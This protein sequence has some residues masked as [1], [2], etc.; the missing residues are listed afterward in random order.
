MASHVID[1]ISRCLNCAKPA[2]REGCPINTPI[3]EMIEL[4]KEHRLNEAGELLFNNNPLSV[5]CSVVCNHECQCEGHCVLGRKGNSVQISTIENY[6]SETCLDKMQ[7]SRRPDNGIA[8]AVI[9]SGPAGLTVAIQLARKGYRVTIFDSKDKL[10]G[11][12]QYGI[13]DF[14]LPKTLL[15]RLKNKIEELGVRI[16][17]NTTIGNA[18]RIDDMF[19]DD[20]RAVFIGTGVWR[21]RTLGIKGESRGNVLFGIDYLANPK[22]H[23]LGQVVAIIGMGN[24]AMDVARTGLRRGVRRVVMFTPTVS[25]TASRQQLMYAQLDGAEFEFGRQIVEINDKGPVFR[26]V[27]YDQEGRQQG[28]GQEL[29]QMEADSVVIAVSQGPRRRLV[30]STVGLEIDESGFLVVDE[31]G[32]T[33]KPMVF[34]AGDVVTGPRNV[35]SA[36][37]SAKVVADN[38]DKELQKLLAR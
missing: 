6:I 5:I 17:L 19:R 33:T 30:D 36:V 31:I 35:V 26:E 14:R 8:V 20:Y 10:G 18:L 25:T 15:E 12:M 16:R 29:I 11:V 4:L 32:Q 9:G 23:E 37:A 1:E 22:Q 13:P 38:M 27:I 7:I 28:L 21:P 34:A 24:T 2:C 3:P